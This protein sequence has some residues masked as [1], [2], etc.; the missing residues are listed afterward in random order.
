MED[1]HVSF[2]VN[3]SAREAFK[4]ILSVKEWWTDS[5][6]GE[7]QNEG[8]EFSVQF[9]DVHYSKHKIIEIIPDK[10]IVWFTTESQL[11]FVGNKQ[12]WNGTKIVFDISTENGQTIVGFTHIGLLPKIECYKDCSNAWGE[13]IGSLKSLIESGK[14]NPSLKFRMFR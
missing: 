10:K 11:N 2:K 6:V 1:F 9:W 3:A 4:A 14:G 12:E 13:Y 8:D 5:L 7:T